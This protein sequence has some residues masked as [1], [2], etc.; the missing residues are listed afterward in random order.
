MLTFVIILTHCIRTSDQGKV[1]NRGALPRYP[2][3][4]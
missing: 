3:A 4:K 1:R 2:R